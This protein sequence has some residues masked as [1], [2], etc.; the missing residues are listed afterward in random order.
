MNSSAE[1]MTQFDEPILGQIPNVIESRGES[2][3]PLLQPED[4][5]YTFA[6]AFRSLR[7]S[8]IF[9]P[10]QGELKTI[11]V[12]SS[13]PG[14]GKSTIT[15]NLSITMALAGARV[16]Q[17][18]HRVRAQLVPVGDDVH[19]QGARAPAHRPGPPGR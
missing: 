11:I 12:T 16:R 19:V 3:L 2:G 4:E 7:S 15:S 10:N 1:T 6:E 17:R 5:R 18:Q 13:I 8:L 14:E 9:M